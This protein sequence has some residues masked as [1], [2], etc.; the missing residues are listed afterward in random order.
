MSYAELTPIPRHF[1]DG[2]TIEVAKAL[3]GKVLV[4]RTSEGIIAGRIVET[5]AYLSN[6]PACHACRGK[7]KRNAA[8][9]A[10]GGHAYVYFTYGM[11][12]CFNVVTGPEGVGEAVLVRAVEPLQGIDIMVRK[13]A[14]EDIRNLTNGPAKLTE[15]FGIDRRHNGLDLTASELFIADDGYEPEE[16]IS[17]TRVGIRAAADKPWRF[18]IADNEYVSKK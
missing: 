18:Y 17:T 5:E 2:C 4:H 6:D 10:R 8:M 14:T 13:R 16:I 3:L 11:H 12:F 7:T 15:A 1:Y 9:F